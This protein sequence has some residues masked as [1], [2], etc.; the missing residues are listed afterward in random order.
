MD[1]YKGTIP[2]IGDNPA[3][4]AAMMELV[5]PG[6]KGELGHRDIGF[7][8]VPRDL[9][10]DPP[11]MFAAPSEMVL[12]PDSEDDARYDEEEAT[13]SS[14]EHL[15]LRGGKPAFVNLN[16][17][18][19]GYCWKY[20]NG[21]CAMFDRLKQGLPIVRLNPHAGAAIIKNG[22][23]EG[24]WCGLG[25]KFMREFGI[26]EEGTGPGQW[27][28]ASRDLRYDTP[29]LRASM[30]KY[31]VVE[32]YVDL[33]QP[34]HGQSMSKQAAKTCLFNKIPTARDYMWMSHSV[35][36][37][38]RVRIERGRW[39]DLYINSWL[40]W[41]RFGLA[42]LEGSKAIFDGAVAVRASKAT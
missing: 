35:C 20:S 18:S 11:E 22:R 1:Y 2:I 10:V 13:Q 15:Y 21:H 37:I 3:D 30:A 32:D 29:E 27:P 36:V 12:I 28:F 17:K 16:Q 4:E 34:V 19:D 31:K 26:A 25:A 39:G 42:V 23:N 14:L 7:G 33:T 8:Y 41:G 40:N 24:G 38:R 6:G 5:F 9:A